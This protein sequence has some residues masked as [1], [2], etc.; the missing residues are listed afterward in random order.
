MDRRNARTG[1]WTTFALPGL[2]SAT[3]M[4]TAIAGSASGQALSTDK[5]PEAK[6]EGRRAGAISPHR[7]NLNKLQKRVTVELKDQ[8]LEDV[9]KFV[10]EI[11]TADIEPEWSENGGPGLDK[12]LPITLNAKDLPALDFL[13]RVLIKAQSDAFQENGWQMTSYGT[14]QIGPKE[15]LNRDKRVVI[16]DINDLLMVIPRYTEVPEIDLNSVLQQG[17]G[18]S[19]QSPFTGT[20]GGGGSGAEPVP[21]REERIRDLVNVITSLV[22]PQQWVDNGGEGGTIRAYGNTLIV[23]APDYMHRQINGYAYWPTTTTKVVK[24]RRYVSLTG[25]T[26]IA[27]VDGFGREPVTGVVGGGT[28]GTG[29]GGGG[30]GGGGVPGGGG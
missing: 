27:T 22:E 21:T 16:Y 28:G 20:G 7:D 30:G 26:G 11:T 9:I 8:R 3:L 4:L 25:D 1:R 19:G 5:T 24:G 14:M 18:G 23:N 2:L 13:E 17:E 12:D 10:Q 15:V 6:T 29:G